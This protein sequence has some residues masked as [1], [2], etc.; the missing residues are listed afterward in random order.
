[1]P[2]LL[3]L[4]QEI[5]EEGT[6]P[7]S[8]YEA[9]ITLIPKPNSSV[10]FS[11]SVVSHLLWP[12]ESQHARPPCPSP[13]PGV[14]SNSHPS[15]RWCI[16]SS[17]L[18]FSSCPQSFPASQSFQMSQLFASG[19]QYF[20]ANRLGKIGIIGRFYFLGLQNHC[21]QWLKPWNWKT[22]APWKK[23]ND[24]PRQHIKRQRYYFAYKGSYSKSCGFSSSHV[25]VWE[26]DNRKGWLPKNWC[27]WI[28]VLEKTLESP[29]DSKEIKPANLKGNQPWIFFRRADVEPPML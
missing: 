7:N 9:T 23:S 24:K 18:P 10:Q 2:I 27:L 1:M 20:M 14:H 12:H 28:V 16:S 22:L 17:V 5:A 21:G 8:F 29:S 11:C 3:K 26:L 15:S 13:T 19:G 6:L 4:F 25:W